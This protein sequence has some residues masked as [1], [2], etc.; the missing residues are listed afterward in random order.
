MKQKN[1]KK[2]EE[3]KVEKNSQAY[4]DYVNNKT[5]YAVELLH[6][7]KYFNNGQLKANDDLTL[8]IKKNEIHALVGEN[9]AG[10]TTIMSILFGIVKPDRGKV[11]VNGKRVNFHSP[12]D[13]VMAGIGMVH[14]HFKLVN[15]FTI[16]ENIIL[17]A[18][19]TR[20]GFLDKKTAA[21]KINDLSTKY[22]LPVHLDLVT[23]NASVGEQQRTEILKLLYRDAEILIFD[24]PTAVLSDQEIAG[25][26]KMIKEFK[27]LGKTIIIIT[28]KLNEVKAVADRATIIRKGQS[29]KVVDVKKTSQKTIADLMV[30]KKL[31]MNVNTSK[32]DNYQTRPV[33]CEIQNLNAYKISQPSIKALDDFC[34]DIHEGEILGL[35]GIE[36]NGQTELALILG[37]LLKKRVNGSVKLYNAEL[38]KEIDVLKSSVSQLYDFGVAHIPEDRLKYGLV[39][40][41]TTAI[42]VVLPQIHKKPFTHFGFLNH[43]RITDYAASIFSVWDVHGA[44]GG[45]ALAKSLSGGNQQKMV[46]GREMTRAHKFAIFVQPTRGIDLGAIQMVH[47]KIMED[48]AKG[49]AVLLISY[50]LD[51]ILSISSRVAVIDNGKIVYSALSHQVKRSTI[52]KYLSHSAT[53]DTKTNLKKEAE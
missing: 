27:K 40:N 29:V 37:G 11:F 1:A 8:R 14:Q 44:N 15:T 36:G 41:E 16:L 45:K 39:L 12:N 5:G 13:A 19:I 31:V 4:L 38:G 25:F 35:A 17:G 42:N 30:G 20:F 48:A 32:D 34:L 53:N 7:S 46:I 22:N 47:K 24:E 21:K 26:L 52:G 51:E 49:T 3:N 23:R 9:G 2:I 43:K 6:I 50:E 28:H 10:K 33:V 18:E